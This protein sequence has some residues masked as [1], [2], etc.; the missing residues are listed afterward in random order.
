M[1]DPAPENVYGTVEMHYSELTEADQAFAVEMGL[2]ALKTQEKSEELFHFKDIARMV[3]D[4]FDKAKG[5]TWHVI[6][7]QSFGSYVS[8]E[9]KTM[10]HYNIGSVGFLIWRHG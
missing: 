5:P 3:K 8:R 10:C 1:A 2:N 4:E 9:L 6:V 7:G